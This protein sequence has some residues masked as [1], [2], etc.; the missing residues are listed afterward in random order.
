MCSHEEFFYDETTLIDDSLLEEWLALQR[1]NPQDA[2][3]RLLNALSDNP[4]D[5]LSTC[6]EPKLLLP[7]SDMVRNEFPVQILNSFEQSAAEGGVIQLRA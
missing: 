6:A 7:Q 1:F 2:F 4:K 5:I 3:H